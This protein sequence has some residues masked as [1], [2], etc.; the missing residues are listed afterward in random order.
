MRAPS[1][2]SHF[3]YSF[4]NCLHFNISGRSFKSDPKTEYRSYNRKK[5]KKRMYYI[6]LGAS[7]FNPVF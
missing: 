6:S 1:Y 7:E 2:S 5:K 4:K 3:T